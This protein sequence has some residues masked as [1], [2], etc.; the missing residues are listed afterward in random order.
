MEVQLHLLEQKRK[1]KGIVEAWY[2]G[3]FGG[4]A[5]A[6]VLFGDVNPGGKLPETFYA[7]TKELPPMSNYDLINHPRTYMYFEKPVLYPFRYG[8]SYTTFQYS[9]LKVNSDK[10]KEDGE[11]EL[12]FSVKNYRQS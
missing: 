9:N 3:E 2:D 4:N 6:D 8:L 5:I 11:V 7:S 10:I 1:L 12:Q